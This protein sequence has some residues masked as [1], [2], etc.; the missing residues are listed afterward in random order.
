MRYLM[1]SVRDEAIGAFLPPFHARSLGEATRSFMEAAADDKH[2]FARHAKDYVLY[3]IG[4][5]DDGSGMFTA[6]E[7]QRVMGALEVGSPG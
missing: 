6:A 5:F 7:P 2:Q 3:A 1:F 4:A